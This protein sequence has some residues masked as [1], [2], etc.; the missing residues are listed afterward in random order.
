[1]APFPLAPAG[2]AGQNADMDPQREDYA[3]P[4][5]LPRG[6]PIRV[7]FSLLLS[8]GVA[9]AFGAASVI[10]MLLRASGSD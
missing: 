5:P 8:A 4:A 7:M 2:P 9:L 6:V 10:F 3:D 1:M